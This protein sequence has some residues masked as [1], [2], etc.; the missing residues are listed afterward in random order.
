MTSLLQIGLCVTLTA[1]IG[2]VA[3]SLVLTLFADRWGRR[4]VLTIG[5]ALM[6]FS[7]VVF[8]LSGNYY[9]L[10]LAA[11]VGVISPSG[12]EIGPFK[13][14]EESTLSTLID[15]S[16]RS[17]IFA[18]YGLFSAFAASLGS[19]TAGFA[20]QYLQNAGW[21]EVKSYRAVFGMYAV[22]GFL[23]LCL[24]L[25]LSDRCE[26]AAERKAVEQAERPAGEAAIPTDE[27]TPLLDPAE[28]PEPAPPAQPAP[29]V[30]QTSKTSIGLTPET[31]SKVTVLSLLFGLDNTAS[32]LVP[33]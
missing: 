24:T 1:F 6:T 33:L 22:L 16:E 15:R 14:I 7:G 31:R 17:T 9:I 5:C 3:G 26:L 20:T 28:A 32:G 29:A 2:D 30:P 27:R 23:K 19:L 8:C 13:A 4:R 21:S 12:N 25:C 11:I 18:W 10:L